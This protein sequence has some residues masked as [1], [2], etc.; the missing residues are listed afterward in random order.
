[1]HGWLFTSFRFFD[2]RIHKTY[3]QSADLER[4][5]WEEVRGEETDPTKENFIIFGSV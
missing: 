4:R 2:G 5:E 3:V 1:M